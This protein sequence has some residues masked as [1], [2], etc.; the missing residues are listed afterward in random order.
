VV[1]YPGRKRIDGIRRRLTQLR[2]DTEAALHQADDLQH[3]IDGLRSEVKQLSISVGE[4][5]AAQS[6]AIEA[7]QRRSSPSDP[8][9][10]SPPS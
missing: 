5:L 7:L 8:M 4:Q 10:A 3:Q 6:A 9:H 1:G 2:H